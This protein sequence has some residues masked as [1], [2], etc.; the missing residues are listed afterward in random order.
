MTPK[1]FWR[2]EK[3]QYSLIELYIELWEFSKLLKAESFDFFPAHRSYYKC[4]YAGCPVRK[5]VERASDDLRDVITTYEGKHN[6]DLPAARRG[7]GHTMNRPLPYAANN[8]G[9]AIKQSF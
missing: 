1:G 9:M 2:L 6:H 5:H 7:S 3:E 4:T 8:M